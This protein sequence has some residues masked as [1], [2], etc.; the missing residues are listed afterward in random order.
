MPKARK[1]PEV[2]DGNVVREEQQKG[3][4]RPDGPGDATAP[5]EPTPRRA[6]KI[7]RA[8]PPAARKRTR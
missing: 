2:K 5:V 3:K 7:G 6:S 4:V 1:L 8:K